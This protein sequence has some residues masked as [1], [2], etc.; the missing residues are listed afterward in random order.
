M[1]SA[2]IGRWAPVGGESRFGLPKP[3]QLIAFN[4]PGFRHKAWRVIEVRDHEDNRAGVIIRPLGA[5]F[6]F[7]QHNVSIGM[8]KHGT[9]YELNEHH[10]VCV[11]CGELCPCSEVWSEAQAAA[12][13]ERAGRYEIAGV[14]PSCQQVVSARQKQIT[15]DL[16][17][18]SP[19]GP[20]VTFHRKNGCWSLAVDYD[21]RLA[22]TT[23][24]RPT[25]SCDGQLTQHHD[26]SYS[27]SELAE[28]P[29]FDASH[30]NYARCYALRAACNHI[31]CIAAR[32]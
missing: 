4:A 26:D 16:N 13:M 15:F 22:K 21:R 7:A 1:I 28:C 23:G 17:L 25:L 2:L 20:P 14:C 5:V 10:P 31:P 30:G 3:G 12:E 19:I 18:M 6:D 29:G 11:K 9:W 24:R 27:C 8:S 32:Q